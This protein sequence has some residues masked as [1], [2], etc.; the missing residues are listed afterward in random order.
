MDNVELFPSRACHPAKVGKKL[1]GGE[2]R[3]FELK[4]F[5][6][7]PRSHTSVDHEFSGADRIAHD[8][9]LSLKV[10]E[11]LDREFRRADSNDA[12]V[13]LLADPEVSWP[14]HRTRHVISPLAAQE[15]SCGNIMLDR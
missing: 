11:A 9:K 6:H 10:A 5:S 1:S 8:T 3:Y 12:I 15:S 14:G 2:G 13:A 4:V 7:Q